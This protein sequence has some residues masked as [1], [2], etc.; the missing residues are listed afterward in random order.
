MMRMIIAA[1]LLLFA[2]GQAEASKLYIREFAVYGTG[3]PL[4]VSPAQIAKEPGADQAPVDFS[5]GM[6]RS[7]AFAATTRF[8]EIVSDA[9]CSYVVGTGSPTATNA[10]LLLPAKTP[11]VIGVSP[12]DKIAVIGNP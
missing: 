7:V 9:D 12:G 2:A 11:K 1:S 5:G 3:A 10:N 8:I 4:N 6:A